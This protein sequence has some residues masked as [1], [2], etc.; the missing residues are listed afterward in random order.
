MFCFSFVSYA[1]APLIAVASRPGGSV[2]LMLTRVVV[3]FT[4]VS[5]TSVA[6]TMIVALPPRSMNVGASREERCHHAPAN[7][8]P[9]PASAS[10]APAASAPA[11]F[12]SPAPIDSAVRR[13]VLTGAPSCARRACP[14]CCSPGAWRRAGSACARPLRSV[15]ACVVGFSLRQRFSAAASFCARLEWF[16]LWAGCGWW[17]T[18]RR[19]WSRPRARRRS[20]SP[21]W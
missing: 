7:A 12:T 18:G 17:P 21:A 9:A 19:A 3:A 6:V 16:R 2:S 4:P 8:G 14:P 1:G 11:A 5:P 10:S 13:R 20:S 15:C